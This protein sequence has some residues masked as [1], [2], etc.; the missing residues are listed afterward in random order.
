MRALSNNRNVSIQVVRESR[1]H[2][3]WTREYIL[4]EFQ[5]I[6]NFLQTNPN[7]VFM[8]EYILARPYNTS[9][10]SEW[11]GTYEND[12]E[13]NFTL[14]KIKDYVEFRMVQKALNKDWNPI[15][16]IFMFKQRNKWGLQWED[17]ITHEHELKVNMSDFVQ[18]L[19]QAK[20]PALAPPSQA[21]IE[22]NV[23]L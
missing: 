1:H 6:L 18:Q 15:F 23:S 17:K 12:I 11:S 9:Q 13:I 5:Q 16:A 8:Q 22:G 2:Q 4:N 19:E 14:R 7:A 3:V 10:I 20:K 21:V